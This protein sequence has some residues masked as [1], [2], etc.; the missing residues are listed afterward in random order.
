ME[1]TCLGRAGDKVG[2]GVVGVAVGMRVRERN[3]R[4]SLPCDVPRSHDGQYLEGF[5]AADSSENRF[6]VREHSERPRRA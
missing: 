3:S 4:Y 5:E 1:A 2:G 6:V